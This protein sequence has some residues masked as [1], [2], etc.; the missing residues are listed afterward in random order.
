MSEKNKP[1]FT[2]TVEEY[3]DLTRQTVLS[4]ISENNTPSAPPE[5]EEY[6]TL[7]QCAAFLGCSLVS[8]HNYKKKGL[9]FLRIGRKILIKKSE[10]ITFMEKTAN[11]RA[12]KYRIKTNL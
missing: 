1:L 12:F 11:G 2:L 5:Q 3:I 10:L 9:P 8:L 7:R 6:Y 4:V